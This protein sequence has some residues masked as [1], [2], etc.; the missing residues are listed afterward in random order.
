MMVLSRDRDTIFTANR[1]SDTV[2]IVEARGGR[3]AGLAG[4]HG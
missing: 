4:H 1:G 2:S 3:A